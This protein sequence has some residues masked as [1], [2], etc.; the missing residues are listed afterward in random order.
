MSINDV[1]FRLTRTAIAARFPRPF[2]TIVS[3]TEHDGRAF[4]ADGLSRSFSNAGLRTALVVFDPLLMEPAKANNSQNSRSVDVMSLPE[5]A[6]HDVLLFMEFVQDLRAKYDAIVMV[7][8]Y[9]LTT[10]SV[11]Q[12]ALSSDAVVA[13]VLRGRTP[14]AADSELVEA[15]SLSGIKLCGVIPTVPKVCNHT[16]AVSSARSLKAAVSVPIPQYKV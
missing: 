10:E 3:A 15:I 16:I 9:G 1:E 13:T 2:I 12:A 4:V 14:A 8:S 7:G 11:L 5:L 6:A